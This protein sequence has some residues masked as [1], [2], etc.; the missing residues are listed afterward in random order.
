[1]VGL[2][3]QRGILDEL[4]LELLR[5]DSKIDVLEGDLVEEL[6][7][8]VDVNLDVFPVHV[9]VLDLGEH[10][11]EHVRGVQGLIRHLK[12]Q[13]GRLEKQENSLLQ[14]LLLLTFLVVFVHQIENI[15]QS[16]FL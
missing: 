14:P 1:M 10:L 4:C 16:L 5:L 6:V 3:E 15:G 11:E 13:H 8:E 2:L 7:H 12:L 9:Q